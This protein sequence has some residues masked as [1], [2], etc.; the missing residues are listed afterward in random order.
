MMPRAKT[1]SASLFVAAVCFPR[2]NQRE[3][4]KAFDIA[5]WRG[6]RVIQGVRN[7]GKLRSA[8]KIVRRDCR[9]AQDGSR[10]RGIR[11]QGEGPSRVD[12]APRGRRGNRAVPE[13]ERKL[14]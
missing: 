2:E 5:A 13:G 4:N 8:A 6:R 14:R 11:P 12:R 9:S 7:G 1:L 10:R 3:R